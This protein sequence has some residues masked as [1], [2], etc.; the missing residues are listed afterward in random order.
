MKGVFSYF[1]RHRTLANLLLVLMTVMGVAAAGEIRSQFFPDVVVEE[2]DVVVTWD[3]AGAEDVDLGVVAVLEPAL[4]AVEGVVSSSARS[5]EGRATIEL[6]FEPGWDMSRASDEVQVAMDSVTNLPE[7]ADDP[8]VRRS[9]WRDRV[10]DVV[11]SG[12]VSVDQ[13]GAYA[14]EFTA[15][16]FAKGISRTTIRGVAD[17]EIEVTITQDAMIANNVTMRE[18]SAI[19][20]GEVTVDPLGDVSDGA[21]RIRGGVAKQSAEAI[22]GLVI[23]PNADGSTLRIGD[24]ATVTELGAG[25]DRS[26]FV[27]DNNAVSIRVDRSERG[28]AIEIQGIVQAVADEMNATLPAGTQVELIR[29]RAQAIIDRLDIL[30][31]NGLMGLGLVVILLFLFLNAR[32][33][34][35]VAAGIPVA[36]LAAVGFM[37]ISGITLNLISL[38]GLIITLGIVVD[39]AIVVGEHADYRARVL[40]E[41]PAVAAENAAA[42]MSMPV[43]SA[44]VTT[45]IA[46]FGL[47]LIGGRF[48]TL[49]V[50]IPLT[51]IAVLIAS[52]IECFLILPNHMSHA[53]HGMNQPKWYDR[54]SIWFNRQFVWFRETLFRPFVELCIK[55]RYPFF[56]LA[57][58]ALVLSSNLFFSGKVPFRFINFPEQDSVSANF[59]MLPGAN[60]DD[61]IAMVREMQRAI[62]AV[63]ARFEEETG[64][65]PVDFVMAEVGGQTGR[66]ISGAD[67]KDI[68]LQGAVAIELISADER[69]DIPS[70]DFIAA[71]EAEIQEPPLLETLSFRRFRFGPPGDNV[72]VDLYGATSE[73]LKSAADALKTRLS[74]FPEVSGLEDDLVYDKEEIVLELTPQG[75]ALGFTIDDLTREL[76]DRLSGVEAADFPVGTRSAEVHVRMPEEELRANFLDTIRLRSDAGEYLPLSDL[77]TAE[78]QFGFATIKREDGLR[79]VTV[80]GELSE[81]DPA[82]AQFVA[83]QLENVIL[84]RIAANF[85]VDY[86]LS[87]QSVD[88]RQF[89]NDALIGFA[90]CLVGIFLTLSWIFQSWTR[91][92][93][94]M[95][96]IPFGF[97]GAIIGH[98]V[99]DV[100]L[101]MFSVIGLI[102]MTG[103]IIND[104][105]VLITTIDEYAEKRA[106]EPA[107]VDAVCNRFRPVLLTTLTTVLGL[108]PLL[109]EKSQQAQFLK[110]T[111]ITLAFGLAIGMFIILLIVPALVMV[112]RDTRRLLS[113]AKR[114]LSGRG[115][116]SNLRSTMTLIVVGSGLWFVAISAISIILGLTL[117]VSVALYVLGVVATFGVGLYRISRRMA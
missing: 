67:T 37:Y 68:D 91:P 49:V 52:L 103:I 20:A 112:Q 38:F 77:V 114:V 1:T 111:V 88:E 11:I 93:V 61:S 27:G 7:D 21:A 16:L 83:D 113:A 96:I 84:P 101:S 107:L 85:A 106:L 117:S 64:V 50:D 87:G 63:S 24:V 34:F 8:T 12:P 9:T 33:A 78:R 18:I 75:E 13:L 29:T 79:L 32:T 102:G 45:V 2:I 98:H 94:V 23:R 116:L 30:Y 72:S 5:R 108:L 54:P 55:L 43:F 109:Y 4:L 86:Q 48:G 69:P 35:W 28:D 6:E 82:R 80:S 89:L 62:E 14:D 46:F 36:M 41:P 95:A 105:I 26:Y 73:Q 42:R 81:E 66:G 100:P 58:L 47:T 92:I 74:E 65:N 59:L 51:V 22:A 90:L 53:L 99:F 56:A 97:I 10:T 110:P 39:D 60:R 115:A 104:S 71:V 15:R 44:T 76:R 57:V 19:I 31:E 25:R 70:R 17:P 3:G 40:G